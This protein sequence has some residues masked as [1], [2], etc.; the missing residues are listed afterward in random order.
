MDLVATGDQELVIIDAK[1]AQPSQ[2]HAVQVILYMMFLQLQDT[3]TQGKTVKGDVYYGEDHTV[4]I[5][6]GAADQ[7][8]KEMGEGLIG[9]LTDKTPLR[10]VLS[11]AE[12]RFCPIGKA[13]C[14]E[15][16]E[17]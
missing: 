6:T 16:I 8:F 12:D 2:A 9:R 15:R 13:Y 7:E 3:S 11:A 1:A 14:P 4:P 10:K 17:K 5:A